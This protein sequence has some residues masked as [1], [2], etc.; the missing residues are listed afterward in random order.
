MLW[1]VWG[2]D[3]VERKGKEILL[4]NLKELEVRGMMGD[5]LVL[6]MYRIPS[7]TYLIVSMQRGRNLAISFGFS[8]GQCF[9]DSTVAQE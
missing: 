7:Q 5:K 3:G 6:G 2:S 1:K 9:E 8:T 4:Q